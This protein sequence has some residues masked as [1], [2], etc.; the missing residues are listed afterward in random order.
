MVLFILILTQLGI[1][2]TMIKLNYVEGDLIKMALE[3]TFNVLIHGCNS[4]GVMGKGIALQIKNTFPEA[5][6]VYKNDVDAGYAKLGTC[7]VYL[8]EHPT[9][10]LVII[11][12]ITQSDY[13]RAGD[14][15]R[16]VDYAAVRETFTR[17][18]RILEHF[19]GILPEYKI[20]IPMIGAGL[21]GGDWNF[22]SR[23]IEQS[24]SLPIT[25][26]NYKPG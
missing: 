20:G 21:G 7:S 4:R 6:A 1:T 9:R 24:S 12:A 23:I 5:F 2:T 11:N 22:I 3:G 25:V 14:I 13:N 19:D 15:N 18:P 8:V 17:L 16:Q 26:V 10:P